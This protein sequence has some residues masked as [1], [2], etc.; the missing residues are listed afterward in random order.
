VYFGKL[1][2]GK[3]SLVVLSVF[4]AHLLGY[5]MHFSAK[6]GW[7]GAGTCETK[8]IAALGKNS[9][10]ALLIFSK[11]ATR[12]H[13]SN[14][15]G[16][17]RLSLNGSNRLLCSFLYRLPSKANPNFWMWL[18]LLYPHSPLT[19]VR[20]WTSFGIGCFLLH[21]L[22]EIILNSCHEFSSRSFSIHHKQGKHFFNIGCFLV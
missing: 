4:P 3:I 22:L 9:L 11:T 7:G 12:W 16:T 14:I 18:R 20:A 19:I 10:M 6:I 21:C 17:M 8:I 2:A 1:H 5:R 13:S 15:K